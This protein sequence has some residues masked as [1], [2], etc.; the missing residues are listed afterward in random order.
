MKTV[1][2][3]M[4]EFT[5]FLE[6]R[7]FELITPL[8]GDAS[9]RKFYR[10]R[11]GNV[12]YVLMVYPEAFDSTLDVIQVYRYLSLIFPLPRIYDVF[13]EINGILMEDAGTVSLERINFSER[14]QYYLKLLRLIFD[15]VDF[16]TH[17]F[18][19]GH[20]V[21]SRA[22]DRERFKKELKF[23]HDNFLRKYLK[24]EIAQE[25]WM[26]LCEEFLSFI[27]FDGV[28]Q[29]RD[30]HSR[31]IF[32]K[33]GCL[34]ILDY[35]DT[36]P[37]PLVYDLVS[38]SRDNYVILEDQLRKELEKN[39]SRRYNVDS[40]QLELVSLQRH[41]KALGTFGFQIV[42]RKRTYFRNYIKN[43]LFYLKEE[44]EKLKSLKAVKEIRNLFINCKIF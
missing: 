43:T 29:H 36:M 42:E 12:D 39:F 22:L 5:S 32:I 18:P 8:A 34:Y 9:L 11:K 4:E 44:M 25:L 3:S 41:L 2:S 1:S 7:G 37:G 30:Y 38:L 10:L 19:R 6:K 24:C 33:D 15:L 40:F 31:N 28:L 13:F 20:L 26:E 35:Q 14:R 17:L 27:N 23:T 16:G 21:F